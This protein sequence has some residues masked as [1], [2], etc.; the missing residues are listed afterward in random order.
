[1]CPEHEHVSW[2]SQIPTA[3][4]PDVT[5]FWGAINDPFQ[6]DQICNISNITRLWLTHTSRSTLL[7]IFLFSWG[8]RL[9]IVSVYPCCLF[10]WPIVLPSACQ[11]VSNMGGDSPEQRGPHTNF[12]LRAPRKLPCFA[13]C[14]SGKQPELHSKNLTQR[15]IRLLWL[16]LTLSLGSGV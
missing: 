11:C 5:R 15:S 14:C 13:A 1:M 8:Q 3:T 4:L 9:E 16:I 12:S 10:D 7:L 2:C 6:V